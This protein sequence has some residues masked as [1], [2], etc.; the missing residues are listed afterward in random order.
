MQHAHLIGIGG[1][2]LSAIARVLVEEGYQV[3]GSDLEYSSYVSELENLGVKVFISHAAEQI[4]GADFV[5]RSSAIPDD[6]VEIMA[7]REAS[8]P[9]YKRES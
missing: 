4:D 1:S 3:S 7:A 8:I 2:G 6:N 5:L 9:V